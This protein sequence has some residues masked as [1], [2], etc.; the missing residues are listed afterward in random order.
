MKDVRI[1]ACDGEGNSFMDSLKFPDSS[2]EWTAINII[3]KTVL[4]NTQI[5]QGDSLRERR[6]GKIH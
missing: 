2:S 5:R 6:G 3:I 1:F 4:Q